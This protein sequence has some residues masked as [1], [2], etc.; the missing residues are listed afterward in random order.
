MHTE[1][2]P[3]EVP[4]EHVEAIEG[5]A[6]KIEIT[7]EECMRGEAL[8][9]GPIEDIAV[10][11]GV[12]LKVLARDGKACVRCGSRLNLHLHHIIFRSMGG[13]HEVWNLVTVCELCRY[14]HNSHYADSR[15]MPRSARLSRFSR[16]KSEMPAKA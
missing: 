8:P 9:A 5:K 2:G 13:P 10:P 3:V 14:Q 11:E 4:H 6:R 1:D 12:V 16:G 7:R 15:I